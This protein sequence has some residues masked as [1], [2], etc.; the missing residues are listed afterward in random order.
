MRGKA[1]AK[2]NV[3]N[4]ATDM[5]RGEEKG[6]TNRKRVR[7]GTKETFLQN[8]SPLGQTDLARR[9]RKKERKP[10]WHSRKTTAARHRRPGKN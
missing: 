8:P 4:T 10:K 6:K 2:T 1:K 5:E 3:W 7:F 9:E